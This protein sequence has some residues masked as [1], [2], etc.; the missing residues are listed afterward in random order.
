[1]ADSIQEFAA[2]C[3]RAALVSPETLKRMTTPTIMKSGEKCISS[4]D[5]SAFGYSIHS[6]FIL[7][8][9][10]VHRKQHAQVY[11][12]TKVHLLFDQEAHTSPFWC[13]CPFNS[14][15]F[16]CSHVT[17]LMILT[18]HC[19]LSDP[20]S[21]PDFDKKRWR[22]KPNHPLCKLA[23]VREICLP[24]QDRFTIITSTE[25][26]F[27]PNRRNASLSSDVVT[28]TY[29]LQKDTPKKRGRSQTQVLPK[30]SLET[31]SWTRAIEVARTPI[32][33]TTIPLEIPLT[34]NTTVLGEQTTEPPLQQDNLLITA[35]EL[36]DH[37]EQTEQADVNEMEEGS[38]DRHSLSIHDCESAPLISSLN[39]MNRILS[40][41]PPTMEHPERSSLSRFWSQL[42]TTPGW[43][44]GQRSRRP[45]RLD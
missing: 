42:G 27:N 32:T 9:A 1:M 21:Q 28:Q 34:G 6:T 25:A 17:A 41:A 13:A 44:R 19:Q 37:V 45:R 18:S 33:S 5:I 3:R 16:W 20:L 26:S 10:L 22:P 38:E 4:L 15:A 12:V 29:F 30:S 36:A 23:H 35:S 39:D 24:W 11:F 14:K 31:T 2:Q 43:G 40:D 8:S 7:I